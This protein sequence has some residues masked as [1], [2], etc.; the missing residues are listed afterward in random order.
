MAEASEVP[1]LRRAEHR[2]QD[3]NSQADSGIAREPE[4]AVGVGNQNDRGFALSGL[5]CTRPSIHKL[6]LITR[7]EACSLSV[8]MVRYGLPAI[9]SDCRSLA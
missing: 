1:P 9:L 4:S 7:R 5:E 2:G 6:Q 8:L 3:Q